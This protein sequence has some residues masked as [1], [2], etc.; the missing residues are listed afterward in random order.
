MDAFIVVTH[1]PLPLDKYYETYRWVGD[2]RARVFIPDGMRFGTKDPL[3]WKLKMVERNM[4]RGGAWYVR[5]D[6][7]F[8]FI[9]PVRVAV[10]NLWQSFSSRFVM[11]LAVWGI[12]KK[13][14]W[15]RE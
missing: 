1:H 13:G 5:T 3:P 14:Y 15:R 4:M 12:S 10:H 6:V 11:T 8:W 7:A 2:K 9:E